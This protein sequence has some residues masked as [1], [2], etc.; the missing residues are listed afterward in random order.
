MTQQRAN[1]LNEFYTGVSGK[2]DGFR[3]RKDPSTLTDYFQV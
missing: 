3:Y 2:A 1:I